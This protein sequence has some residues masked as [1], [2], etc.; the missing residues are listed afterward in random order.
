MYVHTVPEPKTVSGYW[1]V[2]GQN[3]WF[4][5]AHRWYGFPNIICHVDERQL[6][7]HPL[8]LMFVHVQVKGNSV[9]TIHNIQGQ[10]QYLQYNQKWWWTVAFANQYRALR[11]VTLLRY[12]KNIHFAKLIA[13]TPSISL[14]MHDKMNLTTICDTV[15]CRVFNFWC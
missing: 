10:T 7:Y 14:A 15:F 6:L 2:W 3:P 9:C 1:A 8:V 13:K 11:M 4:S 5:I 12:Q